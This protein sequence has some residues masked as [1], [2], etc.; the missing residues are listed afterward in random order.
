[1][2]VNEIF[3]SLDGEVNQWG[4]GKPTVFIRLQGCN[5]RCPYCDTKQTWDL[6]GGGELSVYEIME[7]VNSSGF[8]KVTITG[9][10]PLFSPE[11]VMLAKALVGMG[12]QISVETNGTIPIPAGAWADKICWV[13][14]YKL[15][16]KQSL[17][18]FVS[19]LG[20]KPSMW[21]KIII[22][23]YD[24]FYKG[25]EMVEDITFLLPDCNFAFSPMFGKTSEEQIFTW[26]I[27]NRYKHP[28]IL[29]KVVVNTQ[30]HKIIFPKGEKNFVLP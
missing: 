8:G 17:G 12:I 22:G 20:R 14:D 10:E 28:T 2:R 3:C 4:Q 24:D 16:L 21:V 9:G 27:E 11:F 5:L 13:V 19:I 18:E 7:K 23:G 26:M 29:N 30:L 6:E 25:M 1:M 15:E